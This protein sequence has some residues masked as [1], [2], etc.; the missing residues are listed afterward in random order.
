MTK[1]LMMDGMFLIYSHTAGDFVASDGE[2]WVRHVYK[3]CMRST[4]IV[5]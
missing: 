5:K 2:V 1:T 4:M 3:L